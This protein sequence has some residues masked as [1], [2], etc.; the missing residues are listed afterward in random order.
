MAKKYR[1]TCD[2]ASTFSTQSGNK[3]LFFRK[4]DVVELEA[5][6][7][8][9]IKRDSPESIVEHKPAKKKK[10]PADSGKAKKGKKDKKPAKKQPVDDSDS[11]QGA[12]GETDS[13]DDADV[14]GDFE[15]DSPGEE[16][17]GDA[18]DE[19]ED[20]TKSRQETGEGS[21]NRGFFGGIV[22]KAKG[23]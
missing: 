10:K 17:D 9:F 3:R 8:D 22:D 7:V 12:D 2:Y 20:E 21:K 6:V 16:G 1:L 23:K 4:G 18:P 14:P 19:D 15:E 11:Q 5:D 13:A